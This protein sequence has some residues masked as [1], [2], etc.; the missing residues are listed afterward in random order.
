MEV[1]EIIENGMGYNNNNVDC[2]II[3]CDH[4]FLFKNKKKE[5][6]KKIK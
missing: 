4:S 1:V 3:R 2:Q 5:K 6:I